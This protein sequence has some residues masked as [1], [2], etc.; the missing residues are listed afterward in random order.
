[1]ANTG[2]K[3]EKLEIDYVA[4]FVV[5]LICALLFF[6]AMVDFNS[7]TASLIALTISILFVGHKIGRVADKL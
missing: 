6:V 7:L 2:N 3:S 4:N 1:M 5:V